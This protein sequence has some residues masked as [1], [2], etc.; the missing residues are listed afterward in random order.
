MHP[1]RLAVT[2]PSRGPAGPRGQTPRQATYGQKVLSALFFISVMLWLD[3]QLQLMSLS[4][5][6]FYCCCF[7]VLVEVNTLYGGE[8]SVCYS[9]ENAPLITSVL[10]LTE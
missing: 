1:A 3:M 10:F 6:F 2:R 7:A 4:F 9:K 8:S 5:G